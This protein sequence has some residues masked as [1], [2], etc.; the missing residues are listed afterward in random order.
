[1][2]RSGTFKSIQEIEVAL[3]HEQSTEDLLT[4]L[5]GLLD[6]FETTMDVSLI[7]VGLM[8]EMAEYLAEIR[9]LLDKIGSDPA[10][11]GVSR[12]AKC[13]AARYRNLEGRVKEIRNDRAVNGKLP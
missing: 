9:Y 4:M 13:I 8:N 2:H 11:Q 5:S 1:M 6:I 3:R 7:E 10:R 12:T